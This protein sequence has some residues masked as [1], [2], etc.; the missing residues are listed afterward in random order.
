MKVNHIWLHPGIG[1]QDHIP[2]IRG[3]YRHPDITVNQHLY[4]DIRVSAQ[5]L[6]VSSRTPLNNHN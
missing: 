3:Q 2:G 6:K 1:Y 5:N 4:P